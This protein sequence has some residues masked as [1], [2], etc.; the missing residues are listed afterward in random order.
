MNTLSRICVILVLLLLNPSFGPAA[1]AQADT[2][3]ITVM[4]QGGDSLLDIAFENRFDDPSVSIQQTMLAIQ[5]LN[6]D[7]F[8]GG[9]I[10]RI[11]A[12]KRLLMPTLDQVRAINQVNAIQQIRNQNQ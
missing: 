5:Q 7:A 8:I 11:M 3:Q 12:G 9:N 10:N 6:P 4:V 2:Q 1:F